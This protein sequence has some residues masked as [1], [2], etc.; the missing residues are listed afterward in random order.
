MKLY[1]SKFMI[2]IS[3][4]PIE[5][6]AL[7]VSQGRIQDCGNAGEMRQKYPKAESVECGDSVILPGLVNAHCHLELHDAA[8]YDA[9]SFSTPIG[10]PVFIHW[11][12]HLS[13]YQDVLKPE[14]KRSG[15]QKGLKELKADGVTTVGDLTT[16]E[17][18]LPCYQES[19]L[20]IVTYPEVM[21][22]NRK[23]SQERFELAL[24]YVDE[25]MALDH[26]KIRAGLAPYAPYTLSKNLL[27]IF[28]QHIKQ[29]QISLQIHSSESFAEMEFFYDSKGDVANILFPYIGWGENL[30]PAH[31]KTPIQFL[32]DIEFLRVKPAL[33]GCV[34][35]GP[36]DLAL[37]ANSGSSVIHCPRSNETLNVGRAPLRKILS[38]KIPVALGSECRASNQSLSI[39]EEM[40]A[41]RDLE[42]DG[43]PP[44]S[45]E[46]L[47]MATLGGA[48]ALNLDKEIGSLE[49]G[50]WA[51]F[52]V[53]KSPEGALISNLLDLVVQKGNGDQI[54]KKFVG[55]EEI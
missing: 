8:P 41:A 2:P 37:I 12:I 50:K 55:G 19:G 5:N 7:V 21:N 47:K 17:G 40:G 1:L 45:E 53:L 46:L 49:K 9:E 33:A 44:N 31:Q 29:L 48:R 27:K 18:A 4:G 11:L 14:E 13:K 36:T 24:A 23:I 30:P 22:L 28:Y 42:T 51:D 54:L 26:P 25:V 43:E 6:G 10:E 16:Y 34:H 20:R 39:W 15:I 35:L 38:Q 52:I 3:Q 32:N